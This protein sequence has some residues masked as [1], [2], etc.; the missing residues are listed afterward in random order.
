MSKRSAT[1]GNRFLPVP[2]DSYSHDIF[3]RRLRQT[4]GAPSFIFEKY[5]HDLVIDIFIQGPRKCACIAAYDSMPVVVDNLVISLCQFTVLF[6]SREWLAN[7]PIQFGLNR[8]GRLAATVVFHIVHVHKGTNKPAW[9]R[10][11]RHLYCSVCACLYV[12]T[13][14][15]LAYRF[16]GTG[17]DG[18]NGKTNIVKC[19]IIIYL[20]KAQVFRSVIVGV[21]DFLNP[22]G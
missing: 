22:S 12:G 5:H 20:Y 10:P 15:P 1:I 4:V 2:T 16:S 3:T 6:N 21:E 8:K 17:M 14:D 9:V 7:L 18:W 11:M 19:I 13:I